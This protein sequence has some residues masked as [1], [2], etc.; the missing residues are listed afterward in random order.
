[1]MI[2]DVA[3]GDLRV[4]PLPHIALRT[5]AA[6]RHLMRAERPGARHG[7]VESELVAEGDHDAP[8]SGR[9]LAKQSSVQLFKL[10]LI[11]CHDHSPFRDVAC[12][13]STCSR[14]N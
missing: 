1:R 2:V 9:Y 7:L 11:D 10:L 14:P 4:E 13:Q 3:A 12:R 5:A 6:A 8:A